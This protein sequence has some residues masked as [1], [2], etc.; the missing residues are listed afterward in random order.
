MEMMSNEKR[1][2]LELMQVF[3]QSF[4][5]FQS[6][7]AFFNN[8]INSL[9]NRVAHLESQLNIVP[10]KVINP[11]ISSPSRMTDAHEKKK[12]S[13]FFRNP[14]TEGYFFVEDASLELNNVDL[15]YRLEKIPDTNEAHVFVMGNVPRAV[16]RFISNPEKQDIA[17]DDRSSFNENAKSIETIT[18]GKAVLEGDKWI[19]KEKVIIKYC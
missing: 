16:Q 2:N 11:N 18:P 7:V 1:P 13:L 17:C 6:I 4:R 12:E 5:G 8:E 3:Q 15:L 14:T 9:K 19:V 10:L